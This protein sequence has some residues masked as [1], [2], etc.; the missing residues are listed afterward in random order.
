MATAPPGRQLLHHGGR[1]VTAT[2]NGER[3][4]VID[5]LKGPDREPDHPGMHGAYPRDPYPTLDVEETAPPPPAAEPEPDINAEDTG[6]VR[7]APYPILPVWAKTAAGVRRNAAHAVPIA[8][9]R[10]VYYALVS[11]S[12]PGRPRS[13]P[14]AVLPFWWAA[15]GAR[16]LTVQLVEFAVDAET[17]RMQR[18]AARK[19]DG[20][21]RAYERK[22]RHKTRRRRAAW[23]SAALAG[24]VL[25]VLALTSREVPGVA[26]VVLAAGVLAGLAYAGRPTE[27]VTTGTSGPAEDPARSLLRSDRVVAAF[28]AAGT[29]GVMT[30]GGMHVRARGPEGWEG[31]VDL[32]EGTPASKVIKDREALASAFRVE[33][34]RLVMGP[35]G[36]AGQVRLT[37]FHRDPMTEDPI[38]TPLRDLQ[39]RSLWDPIPIGTT[40]YGDPYSLVLPGSSGL[41]ICSAP[42]YGKTNLL[43]LVLAAA[44][45]GIIRPMLYI[46]D[47]KGE[48]DLEVYRPLAVHFSQGSSD[49]AGRDC[50][51]ML[52]K[53]RALKEK[54]EPLIRRVRAERDL[55]P[56]SQIT[57]AVTED[58]QWGLPLVLVLVDEINLLVGTRSADDIQNGIRTMAQGYRS[59]GIIPVVAGQNFTKEVLAGA[60]SSMGNRVAFKTNS[61]S[62]TNTVLG[63]GQVGEGWDTSRWPDNYQ[64]V[65]IVR[66]SGKQVQSGTHQIRTHLGEYADHQAIVAHAQ[67]G[68]GGVLDTVPARAAAVFEPGEDWLASAE[69]ARRL[70]DGWDARRLGQELRTAG[71]P[72][73]ER[74]WR[75]DDRTHTVV[76]VWRRDLP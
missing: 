63:S 51:S 14:Y 32:P 48:G 39:P 50:A 53:V 66:P 28:N 29:A 35:G 18:A 69:I 75:D 13:T 15:R 67:L 8:L 24:V 3:R 22:E 64:G 55:M 30:V 19:G 70:G 46:H 12:P 17:L 4:R 21:A 45:L 11:G 58:P 61:A 25:V 47:G 37:V 40:V 10:A 31:L 41:W 38:R 9:N 72:T 74:S 34:P 2:R 56:S 27:T 1:A 73:A 57:R 65:C 59:G 33:E 26:R 23:T 76:G 42:G 6:R 20:R 5:L 52:G 44:A 62:D 71:V 36:H 68:A 60:G 54:R 16:R 49:A 7:P 43:Q